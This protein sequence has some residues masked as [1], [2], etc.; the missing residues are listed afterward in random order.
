MKI[1]PVAERPHM[2]DYGVDTDDW[3]PLPW[4]WAE[5]KLD[6][7]RNYWIVTASDGA[8]PH[9]LPA[10]GVW[11]G[12]EQRF[13]FSCGPR[14]RKAANLR[15]NPQATIAVDETVECLSLE[16]HAEQVADDSRA[17]EWIDRY[18][19]KYQPMAPDL[20]ADFLRQNLIFEFVPE[21]AFGVIEREEEFAARATRWRFA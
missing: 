12:E 3:S 5:T 16:G 6:G 10:W 11:N 8:R 2:P 19:A 1:E 9:A 18:L 20:S 4:S 13:A 15:A 17:S 14:S 21:R 7:G